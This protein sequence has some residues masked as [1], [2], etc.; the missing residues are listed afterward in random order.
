MNMEVSITINE[1]TGTFPHT[2]FI[3]DS[4]ETLC[5]YITKISSLPYRFTIPPPMNTYDGFVLK[6]IDANKCVSI[7]NVSI[8]D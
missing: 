4:N 7:N 8:S 1:I 2:I 3:C 6:V 5:F